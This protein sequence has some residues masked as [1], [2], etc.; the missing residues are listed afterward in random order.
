MKHPY[1]IH[2]CINVK[3]NNAW[4]G[5]DLN[6]NSS[7]VKSKPCDSCRGKGFEDKPK[8]PAKI[9]RMDEMRKK[10]IQNLKVTF[11]AL[12]KKHNL[13]QQGKTLENFRGELNRK[14]C[15]NVEADTQTK[16]L[17]QLIKNLRKIEGGIS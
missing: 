11:V 5:E 7:P 1:I 13:F 16:V 3:C 12:L 2:H 6:N 10:R 4:L 9:A 8:D 14:Y 17:N 15:W